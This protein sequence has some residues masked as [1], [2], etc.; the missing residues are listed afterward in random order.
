M[1][2]IEEWNAMNDFSR[3]VFAKTKLFRTFRFEKHYSKKKIKK[4][5]EHSLMENT[6]CYHLKQFFLEI[7]SG[8]K[9]SFRNMKH[10]KRLF[11]LHENVPSAAISVNN[12][13]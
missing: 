7:F 9:T 2:M 5:S 4:L 10:V 8:V 12:K 13:M 3:K 6:F 1:S 11:Y